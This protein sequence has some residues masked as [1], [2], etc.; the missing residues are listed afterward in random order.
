M[1]HMVTFLTL[2]NLYKLL[3]LELIDIF[4]SIIRFENAE[5]MMSVM[6]TACRKP[7]FFVNEGAPCASL[8]GLIRHAVPAHCS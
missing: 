3:P 6:V 5:E 7:L 8:I 1:N 2:C 4:G